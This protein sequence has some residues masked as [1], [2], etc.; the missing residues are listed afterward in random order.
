MNIFVIGSGGREH[1]IAYS[2]AQSKYVKTV[3]VAPGNGG[4]Q[5]EKKCKNINI[6]QEDF[7]SLADFANKN[8]VKFTIVGPELPLSKGIVDYFNEKNLNILG[9]SKEAAQIESSKIFA[10]QVMEKADV[11]TAKYKNFYNYNSSIQYMK[12][13]NFP[14]VIKYNG[15]AAGKGVL[16]AANKKEAEEYLYSIFIEN[17]FNDKNPSVIIEDYLTG[18]EASYIALVDGKNILP[19]ASS[20]DHKQLLNGDKGPNTGGMGAYSPA[21]ILDDKNFNYTT[22]YIIKPTINELKKMGIEYKGFIYAGLMVTEKGPKVLE[23]NCRL[24]DPEAQP[25]LMRLNSDFLEILEAYHNNELDKI[26]INW[27]DDCA[28]CVVMTS[29][30]YPAKYEKGFEITGL[31]EF[32][33]KRD[34]KIFHSGT[35]LKD[36]KILTNGGRV[37]TV[38]AKGKKL[39]DAIEKAYG[40]VKKIHFNG[41]YYRDDIGYKGLKY[42]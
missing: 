7:K 39:K 15:L 27:S 32:E 31:E 21:P 42:V 16:I 23:F 8:D 19:L 37:L 9:P 33:N 20:Q 40:A 12:M 11:P 17:R 35:I 22:E 3:Y 38:T 36:G 1:A 34:V 26:K 30:G 29:K 5:I 2:L 6:S 25:I 18:E 28:T 4:T 41:A 13:S 14:I 10:K 24:G